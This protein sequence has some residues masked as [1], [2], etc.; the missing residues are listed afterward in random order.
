MSPALLKGR[1]ELPGGWNRYHYSVYCI[2]WGFE[3]VWVEG[4]LALLSCPV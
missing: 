1:S 2:A 3:V 4:D